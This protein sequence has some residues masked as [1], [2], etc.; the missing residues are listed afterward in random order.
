[1]T[2]SEEKIYEINR[3]RKNGKNYLIRLGHADDST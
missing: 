1:M 2:S 3:K